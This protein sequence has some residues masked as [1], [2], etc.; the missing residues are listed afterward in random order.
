VENGSKL[1]LVWNSEAGAHYTIETSTALLPGS[2]AGLV[3]GVV[4]QGA[5]TTQ[6]VPRDAAPKRYYRIVRE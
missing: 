1:E 6:R 4:S 3:T 2:W 5:V